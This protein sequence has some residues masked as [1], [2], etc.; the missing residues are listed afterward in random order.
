MDWHYWEKLRE[1]QPGLEGVTMSGYAMPLDVVK[2]KE[3]SYLAHLAKPVSLAQL[4]EAIRKVVHRTR[5]QP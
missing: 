2:S 3:A 5:M 4:D 1:K